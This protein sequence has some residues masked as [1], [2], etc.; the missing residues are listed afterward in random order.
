MNK[1]YIDKEIRVS[2]SLIS[3]RNLYRISAYEYADGESRSLSGANSSLVFVFGIFEKKL[4][5]IKLNDVTDDAFKSWLKTLIKSGVK[6]SDI[7][8]M[9]KL[10]DVLIES[11]VQG[12]RI[13]ESKIKGKPIYNTTPRTY[14]TYNMDGLKY[15]QEIKLKSDFIKSLL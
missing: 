9:K 7:D 10:E 5:C 8:S 14:R 1:K 3:P 6:E 2:K 4:S 15:I 13:F 11:D 12:N